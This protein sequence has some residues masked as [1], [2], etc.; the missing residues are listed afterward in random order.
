M[1]CLTSV[2]VIVCLSNVLHTNLQV[3]DKKKDRAR[4][5]ETE[6]DSSRRSNADEIVFMTTEEVCDVR[7]FERQDQN[8]P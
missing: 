8:C 7:A 2:T 1:F 3:R 4:E 6:E 5:E